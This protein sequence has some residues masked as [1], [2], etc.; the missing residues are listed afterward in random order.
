ME[1]LWHVLE[2]GTRSRH[3]AETKMNRE[4]SR[5]HAVLTLVV[6]SRV[7]V[8]DVVVHRESR[9]H[10]VDL[11]GSERQSRAQTSGTQLKEASSINKS[12]L[13]LGNVI[14]AL[15][16]GDARHVNYRDSKLTLLLRDSLGGNAYTYLIATISMD[17]ENYNESVNTLRFASRARMIQNCAVVN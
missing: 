2:L 7:I 14:N 12:L 9:L 13:A 4:S 15:S 16:G 6:E 8:N 10:L 3:V 11:A 5:S 1:E 17:R